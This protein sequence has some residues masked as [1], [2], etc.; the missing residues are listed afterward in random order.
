MLIFVTDTAQTLNTHTLKCV[1]VC[2]F[3]WINEN[4]VTKLHH[5]LLRIRVAWPPCRH[6]TSLIRRRRPNLRHDI[7]MA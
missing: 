2:V 6:L 5:P 3:G 1:S 4:Y 7:Q